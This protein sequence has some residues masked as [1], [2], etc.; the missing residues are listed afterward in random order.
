MN[1]DQDFRD[2]VL[3][4]TCNYLIHKAKHH[5]EAVHEPSEYSFEELMVE[6]NKEQRG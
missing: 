4:K 5:R 1:K 2:F 3:I 6:L